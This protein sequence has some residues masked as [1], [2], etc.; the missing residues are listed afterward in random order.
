MRIHYLQHVP[1]ED[2]AN[3]T[4]WAAE[5]EHAVIG[6][7]LFCGDPLPAVDSFDLLVVLG[8]PM[9]VDEHDRYPWLLEENRLIGQ[10]IERGKSVLGICLGAQL[11][12]AALGAEVKPNPHK[13]IGWFPV[14][15]TDDAKT[16]GFFCDLPPE[17][18][19]FHW[20]GDTFDIPPGAVRLAGSE[21]C[22]N[23]AFQYDTHVL[24]VQFHLEYSSSSIA[25]MLHHCGDELVGGPYVQSREE[26][27]D[28]HDAVH[29]TEGLL[30]QILEAIQDQCESEL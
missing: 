25:K 17:F 15:L 11:A 4:V 18:M 8:G 28:R 2:L 6:T 10:A 26:I 19:A 3:I 27:A 30:V 24:A 1:F 9:N 5:H 12:A 22:P 23:Q 13:E 21:A 29:K 14:S 7:R 16:S 20:H